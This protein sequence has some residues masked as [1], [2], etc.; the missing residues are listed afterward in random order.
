MKRGTLMIICSAA[1]LPAVAS[2]E[3]CGSARRIILAVRR[4][5]SLVGTF[6]LIR[7]CRDP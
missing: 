4:R 3:S 7:G 5:V 6:Q 2:Y 1:R